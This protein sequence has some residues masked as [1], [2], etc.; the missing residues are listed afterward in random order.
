MAV[1]FKDATFEG[2]EYCNSAG[3]VSITDSPIA[4]IIALVTS[5][6]VVPPMPMCANV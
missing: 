3:Q 2:A 4:Y 1:L 6:G 5:C